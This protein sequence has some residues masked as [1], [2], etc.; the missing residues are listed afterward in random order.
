MYDSQ[1]QCLRCLARKVTDLLLILENKA[2]P[3]RISIIILWG[4]KCL[5]RMCL[6]V[7]LEGPVIPSEKV[8]LEP[9]RDIAFISNYTPED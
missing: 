4:S 8:R 7:G 9:Y 1:M 6:G 2:G 5:L 3:S